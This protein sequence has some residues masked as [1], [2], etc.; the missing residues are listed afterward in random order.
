M[1]SIHD[2]KQHGKGDKLTA[3]LALGSQENGSDPGECLSSEQI[4][5]MV[6]E[7]CSDA[8]KEAA[9]AHF[10]KCQGCYDSWV[11]ISFSL[12]ALE[13]TSQPV[14]SPLVSVRNLTYLGSAFAIAASVVV[15]LNIN[16]P[17]SVYMINEAEQEIVTQQ[18]EA[19]SPGSSVKEEM[20]V[21]PPQQLEQNRV[22]KELGEAEPQSVPVEKR[23]NMMRKKSAV[24]DADSAKDGLDEMTSIAGM[25][26]ASPPQYIPVVE[27]W[28]NLVTGACR[29][30]G[31]EVSFF[32][33]LEKRGKAI[34]KNGLDEVSRQIMT[35]VLAQLN[36]MKRTGKT[37]EPCQRIL[38]LVQ[39]GS[40]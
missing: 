6:T 32:G 4:T 13:R 27:D 18:T 10:S 22:E 36:I 33:S 39:E 5:D 24:S 2:I 30:G 9:L 16:K 40:K 8:E 28:V 20:K 26:Q 1:A 34:E 37:V 14:S 19:P 21:V 17:A 31:Y 23:F 38:T 3:H 35:E 12:A 15:F 11:A 29:D 25:Y 7:Q